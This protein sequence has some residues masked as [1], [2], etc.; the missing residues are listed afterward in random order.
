MSNKDLVP[1]LLIPALNEAQLDA[2]L[3]FTP[4]FS[5]QNLAN[6][7]ARAFEKISPKLHG[8][9]STIR[10]S[11][12]TI[13]AACLV[14]VL[15]GITVFAATRFLTSSEVAYQIGDPSL[16]VAFEGDD[17]IHIN[18]SVYSG[19][20]RF[21][22]LSIVSGDNL[23]DAFSPARGDDNRTYLVMAVEKEDGSPMV[24]F[25]EGAPR[26]YISPYIRGYHPWQVNLHTLGGEGGGQSEIIIDGIRYIVTDME[27]F[28][29]FAGHGVYIGINTGWL[30][31]QDAFI[32]DADP[33][34]LRANPDFDGVS[35]VFPLPI[36]HSF[37]DP[38]RAAEILEATPTLQAAL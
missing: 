22:F 3:T 33:W 27:N 18:A 34:E 35:I 19:G 8:K 37:A 31:D 13:A 23:S 28:K 6:I 1:E 32:F 26:F 4:D 36:C 21:T 14:L 10:R 24:D 38:V 11:F 15:T 30:F 7:K 9:K 17:A 25:L 12:S 20:Y 29:A 2:L 5:E 16:S